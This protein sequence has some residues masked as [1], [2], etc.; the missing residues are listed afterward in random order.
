MY[1]NVSKKLLVYYTKRESKARQLSALIEKSRVLWSDKK[2]MWLFVVPHTLENCVALRKLGI[3]YVP[4]PILYYYDWPRSFKIADPFYAQK[5]TAAFLTLHDRAHVHNSLGTGKTLSSLW[6][7][8]YLHKEGLAKKLLVIAPLSTIERAWADTVFENF[9]HRTCAVLHGTRKRRLAMLDEDV[10]IYIINHDGLTVAGVLD[11]LSVRSDIDTVIIDELSQAARNSQT[12][13]WK[14]YNTLVNR[15]PVKRRVWGLTGTPIPNAPTDAYAQ[16]KLV[17]PER[18]QGVSFTRFRDIVMQQRRPYRWVPRPEAT[19]KVFEI[20]QPSIRFSMEDCIDLPETIFSYRHV[21]LSAGQ[22]RAYKQMLDDLVAT[23]DGSE[24]SAVN[25]AVKLSKLIQI[26]CGVV[27]D[28]EG[29][30]VGIEGW[31]ARASVVLEIIEEAEGKVIVFVPFRSALSK[32]TEYLTEKGVSCGVIHGGVAK[33]ERDEIFKTFQTTNEIRTLVAQPYAMS[34]GLTLTA[35]NT[36]VWY[37]PITSADTYEQAN[38]RIAR[39]GQKLTTH[40]IH[41]EGTN[42]EMRIYKRL[43]KKQR[44]QGLLLKLVE[45]ESKK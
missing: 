43:E 42:A 4:S 34:H 27:Y 11:A 15:Q 14:A 33:S 1:V 25:E 12:K 6:A 38:G 10:D 36:V 16:A 23:I 26:A 9:A 21:D 20:L 3:K 13:R 41:I 18:M 40:I 31:E 37:A 44:I 22:Q 28:S 19:K 39:P 32:V 8:D 35:A 24:V 45:E 17:T 30:E 7:W 5:E 29:N 2:Q